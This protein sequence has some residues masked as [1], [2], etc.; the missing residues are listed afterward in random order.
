[1]GRSVDALAELLLANLPSVADDLAAGAVV[2][3]ADEDIRIRRLPILP[4]S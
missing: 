2:V 1:M 4:G 3:I